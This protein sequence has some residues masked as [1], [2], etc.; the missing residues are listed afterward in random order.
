V[1]RGVV[2]RNETHEFDARLGRNVVVRSTGNI[3]RA[4]VRPL[5]LSEQKGV[6]H[7]K[8]LISAL[9]IPSLTFFDLKHFVAYFV[10]VDCHGYYR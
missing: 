10:F 7:S 5:E 9:S 2:L 8:E 3:S 6:A 1:V 4:F